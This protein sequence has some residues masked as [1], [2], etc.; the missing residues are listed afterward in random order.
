MN[1][2]WCEVCAGND[3]QASWYPGSQLELSPWFNVTEDKKLIV[4][5]NDSKSNYLG[6]IDIDINYCPTCGKKLDVA[7]K[8]LEEVN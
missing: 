1:E 3:F 5:L 4:T 2:Y 6:F 8:E 7:D